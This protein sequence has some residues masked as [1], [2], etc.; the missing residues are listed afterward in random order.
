MP[1]ARLRFAAFA[2]MLDPTPA[3][4]IRDILAK[5][6]PPVNPKPVF[7]GQRDYDGLDVVK[8]KAFE[9]LKGVRVGQA[10]AGKFL[11][12]NDFVEQFLDARESGLPVGDYCL[13]YGETVHLAID[14]HMPEQLFKGLRAT[15][16]AEFMGY[17][18][19]FGAPINF[20][21]IVPLAPIY[22][23]AR[24]SALSKGYE[25]RGRDLFAI[26]KMDREPEGREG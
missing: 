21:V 24:A 22:V 15:E 8:W 4:T 9:A 5:G 6:E 2:E 11:R 16:I 13:V 14:D 25:L 23:A 1:A 10:R 7:G 3:A 17:R 26:G 19:D 18:D 12:L 20:A